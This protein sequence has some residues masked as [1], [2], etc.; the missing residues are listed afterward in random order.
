[1]NPN[2]LQFLKEGHQLN[3]FSDTSISSYRSPN[4]KCSDSFPIASTRFQVHDKFQALSRPYDK[5]MLSKL[6]F[7][8]NS[9]KKLSPSKH[10]RPFLHNNTPDTSSGFR[11][12]HDL[13]LPLENLSLPGLSNKIIHS[14]NTLSHWKE[15]VEFPSTYEQNIGLGDSRLPPEKKDFDRSFLPPLSSHLTNR[16]QVNFDGYNSC[17]RSR[18]S[19]VKQIYFE[20]EQESQKE[21]KP[22]QLSINDK[23]CHIELHPSIF[24]VGKRRRTSSPAGDEN[25]QLYAVKSPNKF[26][27]RRESVASR[28]SIDPCFHSHCGSISSINSDIKNDSYSSTI[29]STRSN[30]NSVGS[31]GRLSPGGIS[32]KSI[33]VINPPLASSQSS[34]QRRQGSSFRPTLQHKSSYDNRVLGKIIHQPPESTIY[35]QQ[36]KNRPDST[37][38]FICECCPKK[39][40]KFDNKED[41]DAHEQ[42][43]QYECAYCRNRFKN[44]N[45]AERHQNSLHLRRHSW[46]CT[47]LSGYAAAFYNSS[48]LP[49][50]ADTCGFCGEDFPRSRIDSGIFVITKQDWDNRINHLTEIHKFGECNHDKKFFRADH[51]RQH[52]KHSHAGTSGKWTNMLEN[53]C[54]RDEPVQNPIGSSENIN[55]GGSQISSCDSVSAVEL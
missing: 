12:R 29:S 17:Q 11:F 7:K 4:E 36:N 20:S 38:V 3:G 5:E 47:A 34:A 42:E 15:S 19:E 31:F 6:D 48:M 35:S 26:S 32:P 10:T 27:R 13:H 43:K 52:L 51:F 49:G 30:R 40:K 1:M 16:I 14:N 54:M 33:D 21:R 28:N 18:N 9:N 39:P 45:E 25:Y 50:E 8:R 2:R 44:K 23:S 46:S 55:S 37:G 22:T 53:A 41:L 24:A